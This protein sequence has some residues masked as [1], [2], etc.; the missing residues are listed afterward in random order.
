MRFLG[1]CVCVCALGR[2]LIIKAWQL[3]VEVKMSFGL[4][5]LI[6]SPS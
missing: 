4:F 5:A 3:E 2:N 1:M 6:K